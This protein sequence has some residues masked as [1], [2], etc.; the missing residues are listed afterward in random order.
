MQPDSENASPIQSHKKKPPVD[1]MHSSRGIL[2]PS[3]RSNISTAPGPSEYEAVYA[4]TPFVLTE[5]KRKLRKWR[6]DPDNP[7]QLI[8]INP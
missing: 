7:S 3:K 8:C 2:E 4:P 5:P 6:P 1:S